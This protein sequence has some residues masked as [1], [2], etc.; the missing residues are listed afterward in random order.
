MF[1]HVYPATTQCSSSPPDADAGNNN[2][3]FSHLYFA[4]TVFISQS[5]LGNVAF[6]IRLRNMLSKSGNLQHVTI[7]ISTLIVVGTISATPSSLP[8]VDLCHS[9]GFFDL[10][11]ISCVISNF[12][13]PLS[14]FKLRASSTYCHFL[15][16]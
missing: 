7:S 11:L 1:V 4:L 16:F 8:A 6:I 13:V 15:H 5:A 2:L 12:H 3:Y 9:C 14:F 10:A